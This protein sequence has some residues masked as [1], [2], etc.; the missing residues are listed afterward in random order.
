[1]DLFDRSTVERWGGHLR[2]LLSAALAEPEREVWELPLMSA[3]ERRQVLEAWNR[4]SAPPAAGRLHDRVLAQAAAGPERV[5][6]RVGG[7]E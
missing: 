2:T 4:T 3:A 5:A 7:T 1:M 6:L